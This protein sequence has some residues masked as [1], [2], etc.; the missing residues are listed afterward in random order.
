MHFI[1]L[2]K[3]YYIGVFKAYI[4]LIWSYVI[5]SVPNHNL[6]HNSLYNKLYLSFPR[7]YRDVLKIYNMLYNQL[8]IDLCLGQIRTQ[9]TF[10]PSKFKNVCLALPLQN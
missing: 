1:T 9:S 5:C 6:L 10:T 3:A 7:L 8:K 4:V 2:Y